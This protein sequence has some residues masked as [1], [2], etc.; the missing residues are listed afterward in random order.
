MYEMP[1][2]GGQQ[3]TVAQ[4]VKIQ[5]V[6]RKK[7]VVNPFSAIKFDVPPIDEV[8]LQLQ[9]VTAHQYTVGYGEGDRRGLCRR[10]EARARCG[11]SGWNTTAAT[12]T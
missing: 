10:H 1:A 8:K 3:K 7:F 9:E 11:S 5:K 2:G 12:G 4:T 6:I